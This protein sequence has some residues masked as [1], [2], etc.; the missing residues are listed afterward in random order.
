MKLQ[1]K[2]TQLKEKGQGILA[3]NFYNFETLEGI[4]QAAK[5][6]N[7]PIILQLTK[8]SIEYMGLNVAFDLAKAMLHK[9]GVEGWIHLDHADSYELVAKCLDAGFDSVMIDASEQAFRDNIAITK[10]VV[11]LAESYGANV[12]AELGYI[13]KLDQPNHKNGFTRP[14]QAKQF[15]EATGVDALA[16]AIGT[17]HG[18][19][20]E[21][22]KLDLERLSEISDETEVCLVLHGGSGIPDQCLKK[23]IDQGICKINL[24][25][26]IKNVFMRTLKSVMQNND[27]IDLRQVFPAATDQISQLVQNKLEIVQNNK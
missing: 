12:E 15:V 19:Y 23:A 22:P 10:K 16:V 11:Q 5:R 4:L 27:Q 24:A 21:E 18:F 3:T 17:A 1:D 8:N 9:H 7:Q 20:K 13:A 14:K 2:F 25:T 6:T 26:E